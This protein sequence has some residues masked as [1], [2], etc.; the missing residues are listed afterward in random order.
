MLRILNYEVQE[1]QN[2]SATKQVATILASILTALIISGILIKFISKVN[3][4]SAYWSLVYGA[5]GSKY[6]ISE[7]VIRAIPLILMGLATT[8]C[9]RAQIWNIGGD[10]QI[11]AGAVLATVISLY[12]GGLPPAVM[13]LLIIV[14]SALAGCVWAT[15]AGLL[16][17]RYGLNEIF[18]TLMMNYIMQLSSIF[19]LEE[20][21]RESTWGMPWSET[22]PETCWLPTII[23]GTSIHV[24]LIIA[25]IGIAYVHILLF[26]TSFGYELR[27]LGFN[28][29]ASEI[30][31]INISR[32]IIKCFAIAG[33]LAGITGAGQVCGVT[34][35]LVMDINPGYGFSGIIV[36]LMGRLKPLGVLISGCFI[37]SLANGA[38]NMEATTGI[39]SALIDS[40]QGIILICVI[41]AEIVSKYRIR[42]VAEVTPLKRKATR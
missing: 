37:G 30:K 31:G 20:I 34:H 1:I 40:L 36:A 27:A 33:I 8:V 25:I 32:V 4:L 29:R 19:L 15:L 2:P 28:P 6:L 11:F 39:P 13:V 16:R 3:P 5:F 10:G 7:T 41:S 22:F 9:F 14:G 26:R 18:V 38:Y 24:G 23:P 35:R 42:K 12:I 17:A 21:L